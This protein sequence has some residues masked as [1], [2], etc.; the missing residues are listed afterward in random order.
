MCVCVFAA[1]L[2]L[3]I[4]DTVLTIT[5]STDGCSFGQSFAVNASETHKLR[6]NK[7]SKY[8]FGPGNG[9]VEI[10]VVR[11]KGEC[12][13][14][15]AIGSPSRHIIRMN[16]LIGVHPGAIA[17]P[18]WSSIE[19]DGIFCFYQKH[20]TILVQFHSSEGTTNHIAYYIG[21]EWIS[22]NSRVCLAYADSTS[23]ADCC[24]RR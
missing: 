8:C 21:F 14:S 6:N 20:A 22:G 5:L 16:E 9:V 23:H 2:R 1:I 3:P 11:T 13:C 19:R 17:I 18:H 7:M 4:A 24:T 10:S 12:T 15:K